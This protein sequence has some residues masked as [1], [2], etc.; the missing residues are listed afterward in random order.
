MLQMLMHTAS[1]GSGSGG[2]RRRGRSCWRGTRSG[3]SRGR[4]CCVGVSSCCCG[5][6]GTP[7]RSFPDVEVKCMRNVADW[8]R[9]TPSVSHAN[10]LHWI[11]VLAWASLE[12]KSRA[13][14]GTQAKHR[15]VVCREIRLIFFR[16]HLQLLRIVAA[17]VEQWCTK[18]CQAFF[19]AAF[20]IVN[21][22]PFI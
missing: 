6:S 17:T 20:E 18:R 12:C 9:S 13:M 21:V 8:R 16:Q 4:G 11:A 14:R 10:I 2:C 5:G 7:V 3:G 15:T 22:H 19:K 1:C